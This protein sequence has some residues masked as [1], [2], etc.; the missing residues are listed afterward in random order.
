MADK[1]QSAYKTSKNFYDKLLTQGSIFS[2]LYMRVFWGG[3]DDNEIAEKLLSWIPDDFAGTLLDVPVGTAVFTAAKWALLKYARITC[4]D[5]SRDMLDQAEERL[6]ACSHISFVQGDVGALP[7]ADGAFDLVVS[8]N[9]FHAFPD[10]EKAFQE[11]WRVLKPGGTFISC[12]YIRGKSRITDWL[13]NSILSRKGWFT[14]PFQTERELR[15]KLGSLYQET[16]LFTDGSIVYFR[17]F[18]A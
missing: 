6:G 2:K 17:C 16:E 15:E 7:M 12:F 3:T 10:K 13:V 1:I 11:T 8:M 18:K 4:L 9:G 14:P 5:Y